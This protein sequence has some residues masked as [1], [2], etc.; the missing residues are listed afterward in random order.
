MHSSPLISLR[1]ALNGNTSSLH[2]GVPCNHNDLL[3]H[4]C[5]LRAGS[6]MQEFGGSGH[7]TSQGVRALHVWPPLHLI[8]FSSSEDGH[9][10]GHFT[11]NAAS[12]NF[13][14]INEGTQ[15]CGFTSLRTAAAQLCRFAGSTV[16]YC[17]T[18]A[19]RSYLLCCCFPH[20]TQ[21]GSTRSNWC[22]WPAVCGCVCG[23]PTAQ[24]AA[25]AGR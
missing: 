25:A 19:T 1:L 8:N 5:A 21:E 22:T 18:R 16:P 4:T 20:V 3:A 12:Q 14:I 15:Y 23:C 13:S 10:R 11:C 6:D 17:S 9:I 2:C 24:P 7:C